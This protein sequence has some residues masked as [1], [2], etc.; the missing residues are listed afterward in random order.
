MESLN[1]P[2]FSR[3]PV[4]IDGSI[5][6]RLEDMHDMHDR[7]RARPRGMCSEGEVMQKFSEVLWPQLTFRHLQNATHCG[8]ALSHA[9]SQMM[10]LF[11]ESRVETHSEKRKKVQ[12]GVVA[13]RGLECLEDHNRLWI[14]RSQ[15]HVLRR[16]SP[17]QSLKGFFAGMANSMANH[18]DLTGE[19]ITPLEHGAMLKVISVFVELFRDHPFG[20]P[21]IFGSIPSVHGIQLLNFQAIKTDAPNAV[22]G[23]GPAW[24]LHHRLMLWTDRCW[25]KKLIPLERL[26]TGELMIHN[27]EPLTALAW[28]KMTKMKGRYQESAARVDQWCSRTNHNRICFWS[29]LSRWLPHRWMMLLEVQVVSLSVPP[30]CWILS[31]MSSSCHLNQPR[32]RRNAALVL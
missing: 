18:W 9:A 24:V 10:S 29:R 1:S 28:T 21:E 11:A 25:I 8:T 7:Q 14:G 31:E 30:A 13:H 26:P 16:T 12:M 27:K 20:G 3:C 22:V 5:S 4:L 17:L 6:Q 19:K 23:R 32:I 15:V 2:W